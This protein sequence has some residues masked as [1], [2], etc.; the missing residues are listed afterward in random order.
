MKTYIR[1]GLAAGLGI[2]FFHSD[3]ITAHDGFTLHDLVWHADKHTE[4]NGE[5][6]RDGT[7]DNRSWNCGVEGRSD[8]VLINEVRERQKRNLLT[9]VLLAQ[10]T[11]MLLA[12][13]E[14]GRT[15]G[16]NN[17]V[18][19]QGSEIRWVDWQLRSGPG[20]AL[21]DFVQDLIFLR[22]QLPVLR[23]NRFLTGERNEE[24]GVTD[25]RWLAPGGDLRGED[26]NNPALG[27]F[28]RLIDGRA[29]P[30]G[31][32]HRADDATVL[33]IFNQTAETVPFSAP[34][35]AGGSQWRVLIDTAHPRA[36]GLPGHHTGE[37]I[38]IVGSSLQMWILEATGRTRRVLRRIEEALVESA[39]TEDAEIHD[40]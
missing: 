17:N 13:N 27:C 33:L 26:W 8:D 22:R 23:R 25:V 28:G 6:G 15:Q 30:S 39:T 37:V 35:V 32:V 9:T 36:E 3:F 20:K 12:G 38:P 14:F 31:I 10:G 19:C 5:D 11:P 21:R 16:G 34:E 1:G 4:S 29:Q 7:S 2:C 40:P 24:L 18:Y